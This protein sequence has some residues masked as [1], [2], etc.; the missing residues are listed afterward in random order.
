MANS[1]YGSRISDNIAKTPEGFL[2]CHNVPVA[3]V[4]TQ[5]YLGHEVGKPNKDIV[6]VYRRPDEVFKK[7]AI[8]SFEGKPVTNDHP[9]KLVEGGDAMA[10]LKGVCKNVHRGTGDDSDKVVADLVIYDPM[11]ISLIENGKREI[12]AGYTCSY[13]DY[14]GELEQVDIVGNH[15]AVVDKGRAG[16][17]VAIRDE[18]PTRRK[19]MAKKKQSILDRMF[20]VFVND[21]DTTPEDIKEAA[22]AVNELEEETT[23]DTP[24][25]EDPTSKAIQ[26]ALKPIMDRLEALEATKDSDDEK[27][28]F[29][30]DSDDEDEDDNFLTDADEDED[31]EV[32]DDDGEASPEEIAEHLDHDTVA[33]MLKAIRPQVARMPAKDAQAITK[34]L[35]QALKRQPT[36][37]YDKLFNHVTKTKNTP[38]KGAFGE[39]CRSRNP[40]YKGGN[41]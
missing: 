17:S 39:A 34:T 27:E 40:H 37:D 18:K 23:D 6:T 5:E 41:K 19:K 36:N 3:R 35:N 11:L 29:I 38:E 22:D 14:N 33:Y 20:H 26:D 28:D 16:N 10:Y 8:D 21:E 25:T 2:I 7:S 9:P 1:Y 15:I 12:S 30:E 31:D 13:A 24:T 32:Q 4:G